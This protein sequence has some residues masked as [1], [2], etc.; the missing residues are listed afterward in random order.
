MLVLFCI[1]FAIADGCNY[2]QTTAKVNKTLN[3]GSKL[4]KKI[5]N[6]IIKTVI[7]LLLGAVILYWIYRNFD[8]TSIAKALDTMNMWWFWASCVFVVLSHVL[9]GWRWKL[10]L[11]PMG[12]N[13]NAANCVYSVYIAYAAN[14]VVP[15]IGEVSRCVV[16][17]RYDKVPFAPSLGTLVSER[18]IDSLVVL[19]MTLTAIT[20][21]WNVFT[22]FLMEAGTVDTAN[23]F[24][25]VERIA[26]MAVSALAVI[27]ALYLTLR[28]MS[29]W[30]KIKSFI[31]RFWEG[32]TSLL[33]M[34]RAWLYVLETI[35]IWFCYFMQFY[36][37]FFCFS[38]SSEL[39][40]PAALLLFVAG[41]IAVVVPTP[42][43][44]GPWHFAIISIMMLYGVSSTDAGVFALIVHTSQ[45]LLVAL[46]GIFG[47]IMLQFK[48]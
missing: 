40:L 26:V 18:L 23:A 10:A 27:I 48:R 15:R 6:I 17:E 24:S 2:K 35:G 11:A 25:S 37:C 43:G 34:K 16:L 7:P 36:L 31:S 47:L 4:V 20:L 5:L 28:K 33:R 46:L 41:S 14:L 32:L 30:K 13:P 12:Y 22:E 19:L 1:I 21:Q 29:L 39:S 9:R 45:T 38:F 8:F 44:A 3:F 42:N